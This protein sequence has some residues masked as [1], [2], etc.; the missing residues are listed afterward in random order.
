MSRWRALARRLPSIAL[1][2][3]G[4]GAIHEVSSLPFGTVSHPDSAFYPTLVAVALM[5]FGVV[6]LAADE[7]ET[8]AE[9]DSPER[10]GVLRVSIVVAALT[11]YALALVQVGFILCT[12]VLL[13]LLLRGMGRLRWG[14]S[15][16]GSVLAS[17]GCYGLF[18]RLGVPL[19]AGILGF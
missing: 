15:V 14:P 12:T 18:T 4:L 6:S 13:V 17:F 8:P 9:G 1:V 7:S 11:V 5:I 10:H 3:L 19:P 16:A 2:A